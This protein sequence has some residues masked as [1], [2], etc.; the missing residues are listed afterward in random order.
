MALGKKKKETHLCSS[1]SSSLVIIDL[2]WFPL[3]FPGLYLKENV[4]SAAGE[5]ERKRQRRARDC[6]S[7][8]PPES[9]D[10]QRWACSLELLADPAPAHAPQTPQP[11][12]NTLPQSAPVSRKPGQWRGSC[13]DHSG[14]PRCCW[15]EDGRSPSCSRHWKWRGLL[16]ASSPAWKQIQVNPTA[17]EP[18]AIAVFGIKA[19]QAH[20]GLSRHANPAL[21]SSQHFPL[22]SRLAFLL[23]LL[24]RGPFPVLGA[25]GWCHE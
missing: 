15:P 18:Y 24:V 20:L 17:Q 25:Q 9:N 16:G 14:E 13:V 1:S 12:Q 6:V 3:S 4:S 2:Y 23:P 22:L 7:Q 5:W 21:I 8:R 19:L 10:Q 11:P